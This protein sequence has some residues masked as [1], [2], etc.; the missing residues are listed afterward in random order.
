MDGTGLGPRPQA[1]TF[2]KCIRFVRA[3][4]LSSL[5]RFHGEKLEGVYLFPASIAPASD[6]PGLCA[7]EFDNLPRREAPS[8]GAPIRLSSRKLLEVLC[9]Q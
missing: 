7:R 8:H 6:R 9:F 4:R 5:L 1:R 3:R 2:G